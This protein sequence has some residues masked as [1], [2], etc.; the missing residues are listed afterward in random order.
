MATGASVLIAGGVVVAAIASGVGS[1]G[2][3][4]APTT[5]AKEPA[6]APSLTPADALRSLPAPAS[7]RL[8]GVIELVTD[9]C[10]LER[11]DLATGAVATLQ[12]DARCRVWFSPSGRFVIA[13]KP[14][15]TNRTVPLVRLTTVAG[16]R[17][18]DTVAEDL[19]P[20]A[21]ADDGTAATCTGGGLVLDGPQGRTRVRGLCAATALGRRIVALEPRRRQ[22]VDA[23]SG[24]T[25]FAL[26]PAASRA[27][28]M[29]VAS[30]P[31]R[32]L[33]VVDLAGS[34]VRVTRIDA[35]AGHT[36]APVV[37]PDRGPFQRL[38]I[39]DNGELVGLLGIRGWTVW[40]LRRNV[41]LKSA[42][43]VPI[44]DIAFSPDSQSI[45]AATQA[46]IT[47]LDA[48]TLA[49]QYLLPIA[50]FRLAW[51]G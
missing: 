6:P 8:A 7:G 28:G 21:I 32:T 51:T 47:I 19:G 4:P 33:A 46:G 43:G 34:G 13:S 30:A 22:V 27:G 10:A 9:G 1:G 16:S 42:G 37:L 3:R 29:L 41:S 35:A 48:A 25:L 38:V 17:P 26:P 45:A 2:A 14:Q 49:P 5:P 20:P 36:A 44:D 50:A 24:A 40:N 11:V 12:G 31:A 39:S 23:G 18:E 15:I